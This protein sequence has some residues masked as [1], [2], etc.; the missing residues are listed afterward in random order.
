[1][2]LDSKIYVAGHNGLVGSAIMRNLKSKEYNNIITFERKEFDLRIQDHVEYIFF[3]NKPEYV[4]LAA[5]H[6]GGILANKNHKADFLSNN[7]LIQTN[8]INAA[9]FYGV[10]KL[11]FL[12]SSCIYPKTAKIPILESELMTGP[13]EETNDAYAIAKISGIKLCQALK[14]QYDFN[15]ISLMPTNLYGPNDNFDKE[16]SHVLPGLIRKFHEAKITNQKNVKC[17]GDGSPLREFLYVDDLAEACH[18]CMLNYN[19]KEIINVGT[20]KDISIKQLANMINQITDANCDI[21]WDISKPNGIQRKTLNNTKIM[22]LG[23]K[24][25]IPL[26]DGIKK[27]YDWFKRME[28]INSIVSYE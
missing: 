19:E 2:N 23:W 25:V 7:L 20:G 15:A 3:N 27:T 24:P 18:F 13:L 17:W 8:I 10:K 4:F 1:M 14:E 11:L 9:C 22:N 16:S 6:V 12:G 5:A 26:K 28:T 21:E